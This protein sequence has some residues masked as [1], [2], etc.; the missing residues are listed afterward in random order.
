MSDEHR[1]DTMR[2]APRRP[3][4][5]HD[6]A[7]LVGVSPRTVSRVVNEQGGFSEATRDRVMDAVRELDYRPNVMARGL[8]TR[9]SDMVAFIA[10]VLNDP[11]F[12][13][14]AEGIQQAASA[15]GLTMLFAMHDNDV[16]TERDVLSTLEAHAPQGVITFPSRR[17]VDHLV[18]Q[19][20]RGMR[21]VVMDSVVEH[22]NAT[23]IVSDLR[24]GAQRA[25]QRLLERGCRKLAMVA[26]AHEPGRTGRRLTGFIESLPAEMVPIIETI[27][28]TFEGGRHATMSLL[29]RHP[30]IDGI[31][32]YND[33][34][35]IGAIQA[36]HGVGRRVPDDVAIIGVDDIEMGSIVTPSLTSIRIDGERV[37]AEAMRVLLALT[38]RAPVESPLVLPVE[39]VVRDS[40]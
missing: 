37:G 3:S 6:V 18:P 25:V 22:P 7:A 8:I 15:A 12:P 35:A 27:E 34:V 39:L 5:L 23:S 17:A 20:D 16:D 36:V 21:M 13:E 24:S 40:G 10:P 29:E 30:D 28:P 9:R 19:L 26:R 32:A 38:D 33:V 1:R 11:F 4:T 14:V 31:F 2:S